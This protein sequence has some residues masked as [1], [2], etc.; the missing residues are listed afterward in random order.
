MSTEGRNQRIDHALS[1]LIETFLAGP[2]EDDEIVNERHDAALDR[3]RDIID[4]LGFLTSGA[5]PGPIA[6]KERSG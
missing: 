3:A 2:D 1:S 6:G 4:R 5:G